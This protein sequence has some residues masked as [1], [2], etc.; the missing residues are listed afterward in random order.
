MKRNY[1]GVLER[2]KTVAL[3]HPQVNSADDG[4]ELE[5]D[6]KKASLF[7]RVFIR[8]DTGAVVGGLGTVELTVTFSVLVMD[9]LNTKRTNAVDVLNST[10]SIMT[11][12][13]A[14]MNKEQLIRTVDNPSF[15]PLYDYQ[16]TQ[17][18]GW[19]ATLVVY[20]DSGFECYPVP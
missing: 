16:D 9:R 5:F 8:T 20:L 17:T 6:V 15:V 7:P 12:F 3:A 10:H 18:A 1:Q 19:I 13:L 14:T 11:D 2:I 4:R